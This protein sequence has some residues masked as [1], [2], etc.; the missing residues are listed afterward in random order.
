MWPSVRTAV[1][2]LP[3]ARL[4]NK[5]SLVISSVR[6]ERGCLIANLSSQVFREDLFRP[7]PRV[8]LT[9]K[10]ND[11]LAKCWPCRRVSLSLICLT[12]KLYLSFLSERTARHDV[13]IRLCFFRWLCSR[14]FGAT[15]NRRGPYC[16]YSSLMTGSPR[17][18]RAS[19]RMSSELLAIYALGID[20]RYVLAREKINKI[21]KIV[22]I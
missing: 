1:R 10:T 20:C 4:L 8:E 3:R 2:T 15:V 22:D 13:Q 18:S 5:V 19:A 9:G 12:N 16:T 6:R 14:T 21:K 17:S 7:A 11:P